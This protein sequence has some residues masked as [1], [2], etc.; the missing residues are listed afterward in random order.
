MINKLQYFNALKSNF[1]TI[2]MLFIINLHIIITQ[3]G[4][5]IKEIIYILPVIMYNDYKY[6]HC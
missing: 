5:K 3:Y 1:V 2:L 6:V 4:I